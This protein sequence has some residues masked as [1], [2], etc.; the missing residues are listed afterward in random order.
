[1][2][3]ERITLV[4][5][6]PDSQVSLREHA[7]CDQFA[8]E[9]Q[10]QTKAKVTIVEQYPRNVLPTEFILLYS[11]LVSQIDPMFL[12][13]FAKQ[14]I[15]MDTGGTEDF[16]VL[17]KYGLAGA[18]GLRLNYLWQRGNKGPVMPGLLGLTELAKEIN[19]Q[20]GRKFGKGDYC[21]IFGPPASDLPNFL[22]RYLEA[23]CKELS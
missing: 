7:K 21:D 14:I 22:V 6:Q 23:Y 15:V 1:M 16:D 9:L 11:G 18:V 17:Y 10:A 5:E 20:I 13:K 12:K 2:I 8:N 4:I 3:F 19:A